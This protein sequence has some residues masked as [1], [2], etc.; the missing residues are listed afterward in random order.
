[1][2]LTYQQAE[3][4]WTG[5]TAPNSDCILEIFL[6]PHSLEYHLPQVL[7]ELAWGGILVGFFFFFLI[8]P[9]DLRFSDGWE[10]WIGAS[11]S[12]QLQDK[13]APSSGRAPSLLKPRADW[14]KQPIHSSSPLVHTLDTLGL[15][16]EDTSLW[17][18]TPKRC[19]TIAFQSKWK[20]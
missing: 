9:V 20:R 16:G 4:H 7:I 18:S 19:L 10:H 1:M 15:L 14:A 8:L 2:I 17:R 12:G 5:A 6:S 13:L 11:A 3:S